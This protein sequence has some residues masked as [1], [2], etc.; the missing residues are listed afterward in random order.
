MWPKQILLSINLLL[1]FASC[2]YSHYAKLQRDDSSS[3]CLQNLLPVP[4]TVLYKAN[5]N[6]VGKYLSGLLLI[7]KMENTQRVVFTTETGTKF[8]DFEFV[9]DHTF[10]VIYC[11]KKL[12]RKVVIKALAKDMSL[13]IFQPQHIEKVLKTENEKYFLWRDST[14][15]NYYVTDPDC[16]KINRIESGSEKSKKIYV[17]LYGEKAGM[18]DSVNINHLNFHFNIALKQLDRNVN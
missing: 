3:D 7:K 11:M 16:K 1:L 2:S 18:P 13:I 4:S 15:L 14:S 12:N 17:I 8:F 9:A 6:V 10:H 5:V